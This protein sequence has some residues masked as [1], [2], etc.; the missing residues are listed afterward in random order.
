MIIPW[1]IRAGVPSGKPSLSIGS[2][3]PPRRG[4]LRSL[5]KITNILDGLEFLV[6]TWEGV[7]H[8]P[9]FIDGKFVAGRALRA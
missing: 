4:K 6:Y 3:R 7:E 9:L 5:V 8:Q 2:T 1:K